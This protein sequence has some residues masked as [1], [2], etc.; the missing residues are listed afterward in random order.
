[1]LTC[2]I[3]VSKA[4]GRGL[5]ERTWCMRLPELLACKRHVIASMRG[6]SRQRAC[7]CI[8]NA[9]VYTMYITYQ[10]GT[11]TAAH[12]V[13]RIMQKPASRG[14][15]RS[16]TCSACMSHANIGMPQAYTGK[17]ITVLCASIPWNVCPEGLVLPK[18]VTHQ[19]MASVS[20]QTNQHS[21]NS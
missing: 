8:Y 3:L 18:P 10:S 16:C 15:Q 9:Y 6:V 7:R 12:C 19:D 20:H 2:Y 14:H 4:I 17:A 11:R 13:L 5:A 1:V 21:V